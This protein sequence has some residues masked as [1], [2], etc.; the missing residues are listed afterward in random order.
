[1]FTDSDHSMSMRGACEPLR[2]LESVRL[3]ADAPHA[4][5]ELMHWLTDTLVEKWG[6]GGRTKTKWKMTADKVE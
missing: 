1:M 6:E 3:E 4:D 2:S 5:W